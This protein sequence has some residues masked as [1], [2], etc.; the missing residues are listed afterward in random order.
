M[1]I[2][3]YIYIYIYMYIYIYI[4]C[5]C[6]LCLPGVPYTSTSHI[7]SI[8]STPCSVSII[9]LPKVPLRQ[10]ISFVSANLKC[11]FSVVQNVVDLINLGVSDAIILTPSRRFSEGRRIQIRINIYFF[12]CNEEYEPTSKYLD[13]KY[14]TSIHT[15]YLNNILNWTGMCICSDSYSPWNRKVSNYISA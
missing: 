8:L 14:I 9:Y 7:E 6:I 2:Y 3:I 12:N 11:N 1:Y 15:Y 10:L 13:K 4:Y 5:G